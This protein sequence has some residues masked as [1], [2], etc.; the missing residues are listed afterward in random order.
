[1]EA[2]RPRC[3]AIG[4]E[5]SRIVAHVFPK[6]DGEPVRDLYGS[7]R[8]A[9]REAGAPGAII[10]D[11]R[12][13]AVRAPGAGRCQPVSRYEAR[14]ASDREHL[15]ALRARVRE[16]PARRCGSTRSGAVEARGERPDR[17][18]SRTSRDH[19]RPLLSAPCRAGVLCFRRS[20]VSLARAGDF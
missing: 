11:L 3:D 19:L 13:G 16:R 18:A 2:Q 1:M 15:P 6:P 7:W 4:R 17:V 5:R 8:A 20:D 9:C 14:R 12:R 10:H